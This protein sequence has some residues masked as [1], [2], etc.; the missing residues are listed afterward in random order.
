ML[1]IKQIL[2]ATDFSETSERAFRWALHLAAEH[3]AELHM[4]HAIVLHEDPPHYVGDVEHVVARISEQVEARMLATVKAAG[5][6]EVPVRRV[7]LRG[8]APAPVILGYAEEED[9]DLIVVGTHGRRGLRHLLL[10]SVAE[11]V[12]RLAPCPVLAVRP[13]EEPSPTIEIDRIAVPLDYSPESDV[14]LRYAKEI[15]AQNDA[16]LGLVHVISP[17]TVP[18]LAARVGGGGVQARDTVDLSADHAL[19]RLTE[20]S[21]VVEG[22][23]VHCD[24]TVRVGHPILEI[25]G[26][27]DDWK[28]DLI[29]ISSHGRSG[30]EH[31]LIGSVA[32]G[33]LR[34]AS[35]PVLVV[36]AYGKSLLRD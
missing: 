29:A 2:Y 13:Q 25:A 35:C 5:E 8:I 32:E 14:A 20:K 22:P 24:V 23:P 1:N 7:R 6:S 3:G 34:H 33:V 11:E 16:G 21:E 10:G 30:L 27:A 19:Q 31:L 9:I 4:L 18:P 36:K 28:A 26:F 15:A 12:F 17:E